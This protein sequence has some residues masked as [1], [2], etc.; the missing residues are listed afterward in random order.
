MKTEWRFLSRQLTSLRV[1]SDSLRFF[2]RGS[3]GLFLILTFSCDRSTPQPPQVA[4]A[5]IARFLAI[6][7][8]KTYAAAGTD[9]GFLPTRV[10][11]R[12]FLFR[13]WNSLW[14]KGHFFLHVH[15]Y[16]DVLQ[17]FGDVG[18]LQ[19]VDAH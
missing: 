7:G 17:L 4:P 6:L 15:F 13:V 16:L 11:S 12:L 9:C 1:S 14:L 10:F 18:R 8:V 19:P 3:V 5:A 2:V